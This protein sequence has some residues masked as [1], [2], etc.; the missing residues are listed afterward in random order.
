M[1]TPLESRA[2]LKRLTAAAVAA[3]LDLFSRT[4]GTPEVRR[5]ALLETVPGLIDYYSDGSSA[6]ALDFYEEERELARISSR[7]TPQIVESDRVVKQRRAIVWAAAPLFVDPDDVLSVG[8]RMGELIQLE[9]AR[10]YRDTILANQRNDPAAVGWKRITVGGC[11]LCR[12]LA[13]RGAVYKESTAL[14]AT[15]ANC[16]CTAAAVFVGAEDGPEAST[17]QYKASARS[18]TPKQRDELRAYLNTYY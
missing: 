1:P 10:P 9:V 12:M 5:L 14:F 13:D 11:K 8:S 16:N 3:G 18:R 4:S 6:L 7:F 15:H 17:I 2:T